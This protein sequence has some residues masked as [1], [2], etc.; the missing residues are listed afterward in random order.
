[1][2]ILY[3][4][5]LITSI[6]WKF[7]NYW[8]FSL[9]LSIKIKKNYFTKSFLQKT[10][11]L[12]FHHCNIFTCR[13]VI[14]IN[15]IY[16]RKIIVITYRSKL[17]FLYIYPMRMHI[18]PMR[19]AFYILFISLTP[20]H[21]QIY[22]NHSYYQKEQLWFFQIDDF[23]KKGNKQPDYLFSS[24][25]YLW[26]LF[27]HAI[28]WKPTCKITSNTYTSQMKILGVISVSLVMS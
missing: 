14:D 12:S 24:V 5:V 8:I 1:M 7:I 19:I 20:F 22:F 6:K 26:Q 11:T 23:C 17:I 18:Y 25:L 27:Q 21:I 10:L 9:N 3:I 28:L 13:N 4:Q 15:I 16:F 2:Y